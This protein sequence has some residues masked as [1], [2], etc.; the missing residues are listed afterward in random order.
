MRLVRYG[1]TDLPELNGVHDLSQTAR[2][3]I[4]PLK[5]GGIDL[6]GT[7]TVLNYKQ[8]SANA[9]INTDFDDTMDDL[10]YEGQ[11]GARILKAEMRDASERQLL[12]KMNVFSRNAKADK[13]TCEQEYGFQWNA[14][15][16]YWLATED[17][18]YYSS[19]GLTTADGLNTSDANGRQLEAVNS[20]SETFTITNSSRVRIPK[21]KFFLKTIGTSGSWSNI[22]IKNDTNNHYIQVDR[23]ITLNSSITRQNIHIDCLSKKV[24]GA[25]ADNSDNSAE[26][27]L[28]NYTSVSP[29]YLDW[30]IL[31]PGDNNFTVT[32]TFVG[33]SISR[34]I[35][36]Y[37]S[38][39]Y[40]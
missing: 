34:S 7:E 40:V 9:V 8:I 31:E 33:G 19:H 6:D 4:I 39:H 28:Y 26:Y 25:Y 14:M 22:R 12:A 16:P 29:S 10:A 32:S 3:N 35:I 5:Y 38:K 20:A 1:T 17:E 36:I 23:T 18:P 24:Y 30:M 2:S 11:K 13:Y 27:N 37:W 21:V 15:Y